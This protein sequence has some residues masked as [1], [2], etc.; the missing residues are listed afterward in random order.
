MVDGAASGSYAFGK[1]LD[2]MSA[3]RLSTLSYP[4]LAVPMDHKR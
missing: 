1:R 2:R 3:V 4:V